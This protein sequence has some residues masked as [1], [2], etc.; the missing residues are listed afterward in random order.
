MKLKYNANAMKLVG[1]GLVPWVRMGPQQWLPH[2][3]IASFYG[4]DMSGAKAAP[5]V[6]A[7][8]DE[9]AELPELKPLNTQS[10]L[11]LKS[12]QDML[13]TAVP[14]YD[15]LTYKPVKVPAELK[16]RKFLMVSPSFTKEYENKVW[17]REHF[18]DTVRFPK[19]KVYN[20]ADL[21]ATEAAFADVMAGRQTVVVQDEQLSGGKG[22]FFI[23]NYE[24]YC[25]M[26]NDLERLSAHPRVVVSSAVA[27]ARERSI[28]ACVTA[29]TVYTG[30]LQRQV[31]G[32]PLLANTQ[33]ADGDKF[34]GA[35]IDLRDQGGTVH[36]QATEVAKQ[37][38]KELQKAGY[39]G[40]FGV[41]FLL[42]EDGELYTL[43]VNP[44]VTGV[45]PLLTALY[46][47]EE[48]IPF[49]LLHILEL[50]GYPYT[51]QSDAHT[52]DREGS[53]LVLHSLETE[54]VTV[55]SA[56]ANGTYRV[57]KDTLEWV[58]DNLE[59]ARLQ[60][61]EFIVQSYM[62]PGSVIKPGGRTVIAQFPRPILD[63]DTDTLYN[64]TVTILSVIQQNIITKTV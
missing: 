33:I 48:G 31:V 58:S 22:T 15:V 46:Q 11:R 38:G 41:D 6:Y 59:I 12:F 62:Q 8:E 34:C 39:R 28:Q 23:T 63:F 27:G 13:N 40:I 19:Y 26:L 7:L 17:F 4:A 57:A 36:Q 37:I 14:G 24:Q 18:S 5:P 60:Q 47:G 51:V 64:D 61:G 1:L 35:Q 55:V 10:F 3:V 2:Y 54:A 49:Y 20:R 21:A 52:F 25:Q 50:G 42:G 45:T 43:E 53:W 30:P 16:D 32:H 9:V 29:E 56:P 44:R